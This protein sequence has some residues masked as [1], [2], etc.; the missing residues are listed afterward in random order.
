MLFKRIKVA[1]L[2]GCLVPAAML[3][4]RLASDTAGDNPVEAITYETGD[5]SMLLLLVTL[6]ITPMRR[7][8]GVNEI[9]SL[10]RMFGLMTFF[11]GSLHFLTYVCLDQSL[12]AQR[13]L[14][15]VRKRPFIAFGLCAFLLM[16]PLALTSNGFSIR[17]LKRRWTWLHRWIYAIAIAAVG[18]YGWMRRGEAKPY[19]YAVLFAWLLGWRVRAWMIKRRKH[20]T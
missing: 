19:L 7:I 3:A 4:L 17:R 6:A 12:Q 16:I 13:I 11:Y 9:I 10:R 20:A 2:V 14:E 8:T 15:D 18:H 1:V 5:W